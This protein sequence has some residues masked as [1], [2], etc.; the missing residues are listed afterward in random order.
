LIKVTLPKQNLSPDFIGSWII[1]PGSI[2]EELITFFDENQSRQRKGV[3]TKGENEEIKNTVDITISPNEIALP[4]N[5]IFK[6]YFDELF[7]CYEDYTAQWPFLRKFAKNL[8]IGDFNL[9]R[10]HSGQH[11]QA[12]HTERSSLATLHRIFAWM[13]YLND[14]DKEDGGSTFFSHYD[15]EIQPRKGLTLLWPAEWTHAHK[16]GILRANSK[17][18]I[19]GWMHFP[20][21]SIEGL[22]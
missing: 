2:C 13:T 22:T 20:R 11:Y 6:Q 10:Y 3:S 4:G 7:L 17:Y 16:G 9:Q 5:E 14:V 1:E 21:V 19:T 15:I 18:I 8:E 12:I